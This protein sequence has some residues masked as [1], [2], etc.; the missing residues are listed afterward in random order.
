MAKVEHPGAY[1]VFVLEKDLFDMDYWRC[2]KSGRRPPCHPSRFCEELAQRQQ[3]ADRNNVRLFTNGKD[4]P[5]VEKKYKETYQKFLQTDLYNFSSMAL[6]D[7]YMSELSVVL[8][9]FKSLTEL[10]LAHN[11]IGDE[12]AQMIAEALKTNT[13]L[14]S[15]NLRSECGG[16]EGGGA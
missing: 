2:L 8:H 5:F 1:N 11:E 9:D 10:N 13:T 15:I 6:S 14:T 3:L 7:S 4:H 12:G 16:G